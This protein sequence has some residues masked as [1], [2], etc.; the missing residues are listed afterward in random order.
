MATPMTPAQWLARLAAE[1]VDAREYSSWRT[2]ERDDETGKAFGPVFGI[3]I[4]HT[5]GTNSLDLVYDGTS[6][7]PGPLAHTH[8]DKSG[9]ARMISAGRANHAG[10][11]AQNAHDA[12]L[13][14]SSVHPYP[15][16][17]EPVDGNDHY[18]GIEAE[19]RGD[20]TDVWPLRQYVAMVKWATAVCRHHGWSEH[21]VIGHREGTRRKID[22]KGPVETMGSFSMDTFRQDVKTAL[23]LPAGVWPNQ[24]DEVALTAA[25]ISQ[26][27][28]AVWSEAINNRFRLDANGVPR[29]IP[30]ALYLEYGDGHYDDLANKLAALQATVNAISTGGVD[31]DALAVK[32]ADE[33]YRRMAQ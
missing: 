29:D 3:T 33:L 31:L 14:E 6:S 19:N 18:Y 23:A 24:E 8:M 30:A 1:G 26:V 17:A 16:S 12:V 9:V 27:A 11:F 5:A 13:A 4:H 28:K 21:S 7:L 20:G 10:S 22:P 15:D 25:E 32:V 2:H